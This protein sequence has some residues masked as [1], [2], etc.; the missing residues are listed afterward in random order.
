[1]KKSVLISGIA[2]FIAS[3]VA[4]KLVK[5]GYAVFGYDNLKFGFKDNLDPEVRWMQESF[6]ETSP[7]ILNSFDVLLH[8]ATSNI[9]FSIGNPIETFKVNAL[10]SIGLIE[11]FKGQVVYTSTSSVYGNASIIPTV[12]DS[13]FYVSNAYDQSKLILERFLKL[14]GN[15]TTLRLSNVFG[16]NQRPENPYCGVV[17]KF[18]DAAFKGEPMQVYGD[19]RSTRDFCVTGDTKI[20]MADMSWKYIKDINIG[21][22]VLSFDENAIKDK[23]CFKI[24]KVKACSSYLSNNVYKIESE[25]GY[26]INA[27]GNHPFLT[28]KGYK[29]TDWLRNKIKR[30]YKA[31]IRF[32]CESTMFLENDDY[33]KGYILG[34]LDG[35][36]YFSFYPKT[37]KQ[38]TDIFTVGLSVM[39]EE[40]VDRFSRYMSVI[41]IN[42]FKSTRYIKNRLFYLVRSNKKE[43]YDK[44]I[45]LFNNFN[46]DNIE[47]CKGYLGAMYDSD[48]FTSKW[49]VRIGKCE[50]RIINN[51]KSC[52]LKLN[53]TW[54]ENLKKKN[55]I[56][57]IT[58]ITLNGGSKE[59]IRF[60]SLTNPSIKRKYPIID[61]QTIRSVNIEI[62]IISKVE[63]AI[64]Y[65]MEIENTHTYICNGFY[66]HNTY[67]DDV[68]DA[69]IMSIDQ[70]PKN[71][72]INIGTGI[73]TST[74]D[75]ANMICDSVGVPRK[76]KNV[77]RRSIDKITRRCLDIRKAKQ[78]LGWDPLT[79]IEEGIEQTIFYLK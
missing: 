55:R 46:F 74:I 57:P 63:N 45:Q 60:F 27:T 66:C 71:T 52:L 39:D 41:G 18:I 48:G 32:A 72:E 3:N 20:L 4:N 34:T 59:F 58:I 6:V 11:G 28:N 36:G 25:K 31:N 37:E 42:L 67:V 43:T 13:G 23:R 19:G 7:S 51:L 21:E 26:N 54:N 8:M 53:F 77:K 62:S 9:I 70:D 17:G 5:L 50:Q 10:D 44:V 65:N 61:G 16:P 78:L 40:F 49:I 1:M 29:D 15:Y 24:S 79:T 30:G 56:T 47:F 76:V 38:K 68:M 64:V 35:D 73:E 69:I 2:G 14:R 12:E 75:L 22:K 33:I